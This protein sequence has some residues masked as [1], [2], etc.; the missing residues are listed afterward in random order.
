MTPIQSLARSVM[1]ATAAACALAVGVTASSPAAVAKKK[2]EQSAQPAGEGSEAQK[3]EAARKA[4]DAGLK[5]YANGRSQGAI[6]QISAALKSGGLNGQQTAK[7][8]YTRGL[9]YKKL[10]QPGL[11]ISDLTSALWLKNGLTD[12]DRASAT[13]ERAAAYQ[14][15]G[16]QDEGKGPERVVGVA[17]A[18]KPTA[19]PAVTP[20]AGPNAGSAGLS[21]AAIAQAASSNSNS[22]S[23]PVTRQDTESQAAKD[24]ANARA[25]YAPVNTGLQSVASST[26][27]SGGAATP[28]PA[29]APPTSS[30]G[31]SGVS[32]FF[33]NLFGGGTSA[34]PPPQASVT[35]ASTGPAAD[36]SE[37]SSAT[38]VNKGGKAS[39]T[40]AAT[41][42]T[43]RATKGKYKVHIAALR[44]RAEADA[45]AQQIVAQHGAELA[46]HVPMVDEAVIGSM[47]TFYRVRIVGY[48]NQEEPRGVCDK[49]R[50]SGLD[51]LVVT[52]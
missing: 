47:G 40:A 45:L 39:R 23:G 35:T 11:A 52:N 43:G 26:V 7:A 49:L 9:A 29:A 36:V 31:S 21:A 18:V 14:M 30:S 25:A 22:A 44:S 38:V 10:K 20:T 17:S 6:D 15:A 50:T 13:S 34:P 16:I 19:T 46:N 48:A 5:E 51:C 1:L 41:P 27:T 24:A 42:V 33:S 4:Y 37:W 2:A 12:A 3:T 32:G 28:P 8:L